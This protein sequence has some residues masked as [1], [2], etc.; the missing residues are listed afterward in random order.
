M[1]SILEE[2][3]RST[4]TTTAIITH[5]AAIADMGDTVVRM[6]SG[7]IVE[8]RHNQRRAKIADIGW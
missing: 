4:G 1:L 6:S 2:V 8:R 5:N 7:A 3:N